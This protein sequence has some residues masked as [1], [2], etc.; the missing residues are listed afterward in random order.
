MAVTK[1][2]KISV[3]VTG[4]TS[5]MAAV[6]ADLRRSRALVIG[7]GRSASAAGG[8]GLSRAASQRGWSF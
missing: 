3:I 4:A 2:W 1:I 7:V 5:G 8:Q 6:A